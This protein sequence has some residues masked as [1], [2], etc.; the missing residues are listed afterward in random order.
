MELQNWIRGLGYPET[1]KEIYD[2][3]DE[4]ERC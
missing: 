2:L 4:E 1:L 3:Q